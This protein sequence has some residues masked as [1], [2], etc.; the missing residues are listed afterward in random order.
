MKPKFGNIR[1]M[2]TRDQM[3]KIRGGQ[4]CTTYKCCKNG[5]CSSCLY[6]AQENCPEGDE[7]KS[8]C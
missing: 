1:E 7:K 2:L 4:A 8:C 3:K 5:S 6:N